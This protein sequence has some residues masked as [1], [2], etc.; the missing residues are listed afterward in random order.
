[1]CRAWAGGCRAK[2]ATC[3]VGQGG[4]TLCM[5]VAGLHPEAPP[6]VAAAAGLSL[7]EYAALVWAGA[8]TLEE[9]LKVSVWLNHGTCFAWWGPAAGGPGLCLPQRPPPPEASYKQHVLQGR[10]PLLGLHTA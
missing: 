6:A 3:H 7:G 8:L 9:G 10:R 4:L 2:A 5:Q 1:M